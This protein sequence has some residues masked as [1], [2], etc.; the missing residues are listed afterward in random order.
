MLAW[1]LGA[2][3]GIFLSSC[4]FLKEEGTGNVRESIKRPKKGVHTFSLW[5]AVLFYKQRDINF[6]TMACQ[7]IL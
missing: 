4:K 3:T 1:K 6:K 7:F 5:P 2:V